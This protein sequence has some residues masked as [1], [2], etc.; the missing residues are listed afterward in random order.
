MIASV[1]PEFVECELIVD[2]YSRLRWREVGI[3]GP[4]WRSTQRS[5]E[6]LE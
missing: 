5:L 1:P 2:R 4:Q 6:K 3:V